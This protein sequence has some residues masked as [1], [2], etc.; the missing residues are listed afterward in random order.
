MDKDTSKFIDDVV[1]LSK[2]TMFLGAEDDLGIVVALIGMALPLMTIMYRDRL[3]G[4]TTVEDIAERFISTIRIRIV[5]IHN[6]NKSL[7]NILYSSI[8]H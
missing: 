3:V 5:L 8:T 1:Q 2:D 4:D 6:T 7:C